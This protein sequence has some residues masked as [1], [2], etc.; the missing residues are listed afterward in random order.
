MS[1]L[2]WIEEFPC[3][4]T[5]CDVAGRILEM[6]AKAGATFQNRGG[7]AL[8]GKDLFDCHQ[9]SSRQKI[10]EILERERPNCYTIEKEGMKKLIYQSPWYRDGTLQGLVEISIPLP[11]ELPHFVRE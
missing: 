2:D 4:I 10:R 6:N 11:A 3:A 1:N 5:V 7:K 9:E 8:I